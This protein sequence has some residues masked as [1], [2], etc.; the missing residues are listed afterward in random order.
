[1]ESRRSTLDVVCVAMTISDILDR[2]EHPSLE[3]R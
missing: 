1:M 2:S 3:E